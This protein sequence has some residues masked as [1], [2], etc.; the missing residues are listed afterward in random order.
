VRKKNH[1]ADIAFLGVV[2]ILVLVLLYSGLRVLESA[3]LRGSQQEQNAATDKTLVREDVHYFP[4]QDITVVLV[5]GID[6]YGPVSDSEAY[7]NPGAADMV[8]LL[9][10]DEKNEVCNVLNINRDMMVDMPVLNEHG[11]AIGVG[12]AQLAYSHAYG[13][14][15][16]DS[17]ENVRMTVSNLLYG[18]QIDYYFAL[19][20]DTISILNDSVGGVK[21]NVVDDFSEVDPSLPMGEVLLKGKQAV[22]F[23]QSRGSV[24]DELNLSRMERQQEYMS[25]FVPA[26]KNQ[27]KQDS[28][29][30]TNTYEEISDFIVT[31]CILDSVSRLASDYADYPLGEMLAIEGTNILGETYYEF[32]AD[33]EALDEL[34]LRLF[35]AP[36]K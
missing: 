23:V 18:L 19:N 4:R 11:K 16:K 29:Y 21:V 12:N 32:Y 5:M 20:M 9:I 28:S 30:V 27:I 36:K 1:L 33:E 24:G 2:L 6:Q 17:C 34:I 10:F 8:M 14:G 26:L 13:K 15:M 35:Y 22:S 7:N 31:D 3:V 25:N